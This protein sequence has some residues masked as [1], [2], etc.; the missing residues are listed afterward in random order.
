[1]LFRS[2]RIDDL[3][4]ALTLHAAGGRLL[5]RGAGGGDAGAGADAREVPF[6]AP[7]RIGKLSLT[8]TSV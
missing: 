1:M 2:V 7:V 6:G 5:C 4:S 8:L 3:E